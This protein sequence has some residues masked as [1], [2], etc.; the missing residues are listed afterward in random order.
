MLGSLTTSRDP[1]TLS[2]GRAEAAIM[3]KFQPVL[4]KLN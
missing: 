1:K 3:A 2:I 4:M